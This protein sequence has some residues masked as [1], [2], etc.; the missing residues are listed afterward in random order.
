FPKNLKFSTRKSIWRQTHNRTIQEEFIDWN[1]KYL[2]DV[3][4]FNKKLVDWLLWYNTQRPH[5]SLRLQSPVDYL[6]NN[7]L[8]SK[9]RWTDTLN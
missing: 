6:I 1:E 7:K 2:T 9:M 3:N 4:E 8:L 5:W